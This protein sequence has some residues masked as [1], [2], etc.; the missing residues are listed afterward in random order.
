[1][2]TRRYDK[3]I[4]GVYLHYNK[5]RTVFGVGL[6]SPDSV[7]NALG[8]YL[9]QN[10]RPT[11]N[12][13]TQRIAST[14]RTLV[15]NV[16]V[17]NYV[18]EDIPQDEIVAKLIKA[19]QE[20]VQ[21]HLD[22]EAVTLGYDNINNCRICINSDIPK[23]LADGLAGQWLYDQCWA[24]CYEILGVGEMVTVDEVIEQLPSI[25]DYVSG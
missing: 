19:V 15:A 1:M 8:W 24:L 13:A 20:A 25:G 5:M 10:E 9:V 3:V 7:C 2:D 16:S 21:N 17:I 22:T 18:I 12:R 14:T 6:R 4:D 23:F 11:I